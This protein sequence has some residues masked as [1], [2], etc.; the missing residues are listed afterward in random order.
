MPADRPCPNLPEEGAPTPTL[1]N[2]SQHSNGDLPSSRLPM[3]H[4]A[5]YI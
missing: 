4:H 5:D 1:S 2:A 3:K